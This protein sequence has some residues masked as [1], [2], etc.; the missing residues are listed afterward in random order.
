MEA[1]KWFGRW[2]LTVGISATAAAAASIAAAAANSFECCKLDRSGA[3]VETAGSSL[4]RLGTHGSRSSARFLPSSPIPAIAGPSPP[5]RSSRPSPSRASGSRSPYDAFFLL[6]GGIAET[7]PSLQGICGH[8]VL[9][10]FVATASS[11]MA[12][13]CRLSLLR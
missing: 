12:E 3:G 5:L 6:S 10:L 11:L 8:G 4:F 13:S 9:R 1:R 7:G 2:C